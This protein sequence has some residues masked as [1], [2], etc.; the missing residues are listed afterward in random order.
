MPERVRSDAVETIRADL[1]RSGGTS[2]PEVRVPAADADSLPEDVVRVSIDGHLYHA[3]VV[4]VADGISLRGAYDNRRR[5]KEREGTDRLAEWVDS[6]GLAF[7]RTVL[8]D[9][10]VPETQYGLRA[11]GDEAVYRVQSSPAGDLQDIAESLE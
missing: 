4:A 9:V 11:P 8:L 5:A 2:R 3:P 7:G 10:V 1:A 6:V